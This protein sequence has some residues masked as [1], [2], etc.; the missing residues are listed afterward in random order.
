MT[1]YNRLLIFGALLAA[2]VCLCP[3]VT[4]A[5]NYAAEVSEAQAQARADETAGKFKSAAEEYLAVELYANDPALK[6]EAL[7][8]AAANFRKA[9]LYG[10]ELDCLIRLVNEHIHRIDFNEV[11]SRMYEIGF[12]FYD[13]HKD[14]YVSWLP[15]IYGEN[16]AEA[17]FK[18][19]LK[20]APCAP[21]AAR[22]R[23][24]LGILYEESGRPMLARDKFE[25][26]M[27]LHPDSREHRMAY[28]ELAYLYYQLAQVG[29]GDGKNTN[30]A[31]DMLDKFIE[32][33]PNDPEIPWARKTRAE[34]DSITAKRLH[35]LAEYYHRTGQDD[36][37]KQYLNRVISKFGSSRDAIP[38]EQLLAELDEAYQAPGPDAPREKKPEIVI[39]R[40]TIPVER[41][42]ILIVPEAS[43][44][45]FLL[46]V[47]DL[48][49]NQKRDSRDPAPASLK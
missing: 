15:F 47:R 32:L 35:A 18:E 10:N 14:I 37:S 44:G 1:G 30:A 48:K 24:T 45:R 31:I 17:A 8:N 4:A 20:Q 6:A 33:Y 5:G 36:M 42:P 38:S 29:D 27:K 22:A 2:A 16:K 12:A 41:Q 21:Q 40:N 23:L 43:D 39:K 13:G 11:V 46:P 9:G 25:E 26:I 49:I 19:A 28:I 3:S 7:K 34:L